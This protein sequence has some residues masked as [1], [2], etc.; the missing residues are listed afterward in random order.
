MDASDILDDLLSN[1]RTELGDGFSAISNFARV[2]GEMLAKQ[3]ARIARSRIDGDLADDDDF[4]NWLLGGLERDTANM[5]RSIAVLTV[6]T[7]EKAWNALVNALWG[8]IRSILT[9]A[10]LPAPLIPETPPHA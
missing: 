4:Y 9:A 2:Q 6:L 7:I 10:G 5:A 8:G 1:L 3:A